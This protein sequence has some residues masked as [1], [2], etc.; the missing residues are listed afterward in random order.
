ML[1]PFLGRWVARGDARRF[2]SIA[3]AAWALVAFW[4]TGMTTG[5]TAGEIALI[6]LFQGFGMAFFL[7]PLVSLSLMGLPQDK[8]AAASGLQTA[9]RMLAGSIFAALGQTFWDQRSRFHQ[10]HLVDALGSDERSRTTLQLLR[11]NGFDTEQAWGLINRQLDLQ[12]H[13]LALNDFFFFS[14]FAFGAA[15]GIIWFAHGPSEQ[16]S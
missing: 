12:A 10:N 3:F 7:T 8:L 15:L 13:M 1:A 4:R 16:K 6:H 5:V 9:I 2:A 11:E 14:T